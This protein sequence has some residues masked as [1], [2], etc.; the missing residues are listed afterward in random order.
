[1]QLTT[2]TMAR[3][4]DPNPHYTRRHPLSMDRKKTHDLSPSAMMVAF[5][6]KICHIITHSHKG[7]VHK[8]HYTIFSEGNQSEH[9]MSWMFHKN[10]HKAVIHPIAPTVCDIRHR[11]LIRCTVFFISF[12]SNSLTSMIPL[13]SLS[14]T[15]SSG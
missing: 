15:K 6:Q 13:Q 2:V 7:H 11:I 12:S 14:S 8:Q 10:I 9:P 4:Q 1:M 3:A 5:T